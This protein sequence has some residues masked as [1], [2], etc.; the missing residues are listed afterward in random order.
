MIPKDVTRLLLTTTHAKV[1]LAFSLSSR[2][3]SSVIQEEKFQ[4]SSRVRLRTTRVLNRASYSHSCEILK[5]CL[6]NGDRDGYVKMLDDNGYS[7]CQW[8]NDKQH[9]T[10][11]VVLNRHR[12]RQGHYN[13]RVARRYWNNGML[14]GLDQ[15]W[16]QDRLLQYSCLYERNR[17]LTPL[18][19][20]SYHFGYGSRVEYLL[21]PNGALKDMIV[22]GV[23][24]Q[25]W[26][27][28][29]QLHTLNER[30]DR[31]WI[32]KV[33]TRNG[34]LKSVTW[35]DT[36]TQET[37]YRDGSRK[38][39][40]EMISYVYMSEVEFWSASGRLLHKY[41]LEAVRTHWS[42]PNKKSFRKVGLESKWNGK[43]KLI[44]E[45]DHKHYAL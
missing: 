28:N 39:V 5:E 9:G 25:T 35:L 43:G 44:S 10:E 11:I 8:R 1:F 18:E 7:M 2:T 36:E 16:D 32:K 13:I 42:K 24:H 19:W 33:Y 21:Y 3:N 31:R 45:V 4:N 27:Q 12:H 6:P 14:H 20:P 40:K 17:P 22:P 38:I 23:S 37:R 26:Y 34:K 41:T 30:E 29:G 15:R